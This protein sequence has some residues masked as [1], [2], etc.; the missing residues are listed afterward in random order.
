MMKALRSSRS[1]LPT[2][3]V[4]SV[5]MAE[6]AASTASPDDGGGGTAVLAMKESMSPPRR[7]KM[8]ASAAEAEFGVP[9][10]SSSEEGVSNLRENQLILVVRMWLNTN[11][12]TWCLFAPL[13]LRL[14]QSP[15]FRL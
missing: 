6:E 1:P 13:G 8:A 12:L 3:G 9:A 2:P 11:Y 7:W 15:E 5:I 14:I 10:D 4:L